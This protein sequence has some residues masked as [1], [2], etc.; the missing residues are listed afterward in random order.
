[1]EEDD[2]NFY[3]EIDDLLDNDELSPF[4]QAFMEGYNSAWGEQDGKNRKWTHQGAS[5]AWI[6]IFKPRDSKK[7]GDKDGTRGNFQKA[8]RWWLRWLLF[9]I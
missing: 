8:Y 4:E 6:D 3:D 2:L 7:L 1:M 5:V 9:K